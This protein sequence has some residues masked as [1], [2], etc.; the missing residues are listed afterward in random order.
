MAGT[1]GKSDLLDLTGIF[2]GNKAQ[3][4]RLK[5]ILFPGEAAVAKTMAAFVKIQRG[6]YRLPAGIPHRIPFLDIEI[7][8]VVVIGN[9]V[10]PVTGNAKKLRIFIKAVPAAGIRDQT[11]KAIG[12]QIIDP[13]QWSIRA[14]NDIFHRSVIKKSILHSE[15]PP[16]YYTNAENDLG[17]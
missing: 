5:F 13:R 2:F 1:V 7:V 11:E 10:I 16:D 4:L 12:P 8:T 15:N 3:N 17:I 6:F 9:I 14:L